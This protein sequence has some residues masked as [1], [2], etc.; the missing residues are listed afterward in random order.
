MEWLIGLGANVN[1]RNSSEK[2]PLHVAAANGQAFAVSF[3]LRS[4]VDAA[5]VDED[6]QSAAQAAKDKN[7]PDLKREIEEH[8]Q[9][10]R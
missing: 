10:T 6:V 4:G 5:A 8:L 7:R 1:A 3:L 9:L 2:T